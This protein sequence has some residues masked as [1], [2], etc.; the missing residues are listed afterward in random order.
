MEAGRSGN[1]TAAA[2]PA[3]GSRRWLRIAIVVL[4]VAAALIAWLATQGG[5]DDKGS[6]GGSAEAG[7]ARIVSPAELGDVAATAG[8][9]VYW[10]GPMPGAELE[11][12]ELP[13]GGTQVRYPPEGSEAGEGSVETTT[14]GSYP[15]PDP[16]AQLDGFAKRQGSTVHRAGGREVVVST[17]RPT[18]AYFVSPDNSV[19]VEV[20]DPSP[21]RALRL[22][23]SAKVRPAR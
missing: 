2:P 20:Y 5:D 6:G 18:S 9:P 12:T 1:G 14:I 16:Q 22:A 8:H 3:P 15:L 7:A 17:E 11:L 23:L 21:Q 13:D 4:A 10:A 19:Q